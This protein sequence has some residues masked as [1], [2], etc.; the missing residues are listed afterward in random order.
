M[1]LTAFGAMLAVTLFALL[2][3]L[4]VAAVPTIYRTFIV[5]PLDPRLL[6]MTFTLLVVSS[7]ASAL[8]PSL[9]AFR[10]DPL[11]AL[12]SSSAATTA[13]PDRAGRLF[14]GLAAALAVALV[15]LSVITLPPFL[16][17]VLR[18][19]G[20]N[21]AELFVLTANHNWASAADGSPVHERR[22][23]AIVRAIA[24]VRGVESAAVTLNPL[25]EASSGES[26]FWERL[27]TQG[28]EQAIGAGLFSTLKTRVLAGRELTFQ[29]TDQNAMVAIVNA[30]A[31]AK[32]WPRDPVSTVI[33][34]SV[35]TTDGSRIVIGVVE[36]I[37]YEATG[38]VLPTL[39]LPIGARD[40]A[41]TQTSVTVFVRMAAGSEPSAM[42]FQAALNSAFPPGIVRLQSVSLLRDPILAGPRFM[43]ALTTVL[44][45]VT[46]CLAIVGLHS[47]SQFEAQTRRRELAIRVA[48]G[49][50]PHRLEWMATR[51]L[52]VPLLIGTVIGGLVVIAGASALENT[53]AGAA[54]ARVSGSLV[55][56]AIVSVIGCT[57]CWVPVRRIARGNVLISL[58]ADR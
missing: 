54:A 3:P 25:F 35:A 8:T 18:S 2:R 15:A 26:A 46:V 28:R 32:L 21:P 33:G 13:V 50:S 11:L 4:I 34:R 40:V 19:P 38:D 42:A 47:V 7:V 14:V 29:D 41:P 56:T 37:D 58:K 1:F 39:F 43:A 51:K 17:I 9:L 44:A 49:A 27:G 52:L 48:L 22:A 23:A 20:F 53:L 45:A 55:A 36:D 30:T 5:S 12:R 6:A 31:A 16:R 24:A 57:A 10:V